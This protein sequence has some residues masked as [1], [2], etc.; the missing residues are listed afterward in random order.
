MKLRLVLFV[1][2]SFMAA[3]MLAQPQKD[4]HFSR[5]FADVGKIKEENGKVNEYFY[6]RN[7]SDK[8]YKIEEIVT[9]CPCM[10]SAVSQK[11][12]APGDTA[13]I[14]LTYDPKGRVG[15]F[16]RR[17]E[18]FFEGF[19]A[20][21]IQIGVRGLVSTSKVHPMADRYPLSIGNLRFKSINFPLYKIF[22]PDLSVDTFPIYNQL[23]RPM[24][25]GFT[26]LPAHISC[27]AVPEVLP[28]ETEGIVLI[29]YD[30]VKKDQWGH[31][32]DYFAIQTDDIASETKMIRVY[33]SIEEDFSKLSEKALKRAPSIIFDTTEY[34]FGKI[35]PGDTVR[36]KF[37]FQNAGKEDLII[38]QV[39]SSC[40]CTATEPEKKTIK[41]G[42]KSNI[43]LIFDSSGRTGN[44]YKYA[45]ITTNDPINTE[46]KVTLHGTIVS[47]K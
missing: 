24:K 38:R 47:E 17:V 26:Q 40:G 19:P 14:I 6:V 20:A 21:P 11:D 16:V 22:Y 46:V 15:V 12:I 37:H 2:L 4:L 45:I 7:T 39:R 35:Q 36:V 28:A 34:D 3:S 18:I 8:E 29:T 41:P 32:T 1:S 43:Q 13:S 25:I 42:E 31:V 44:Q 30:P 23:D 10:E 5:K 9:D 27:E 33:G